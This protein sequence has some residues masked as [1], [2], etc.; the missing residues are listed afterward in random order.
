VF[1]ERQPRQRRISTLPQH[2]GRLQHR[3]S[4]AKTRRG[5]E[6]RQWYIDE[7]AQL[8]KNAPAWNEM[9]AIGG[10]GNPGN[11]Q[12]FAHETP[13]VSIFLVVLYRNSV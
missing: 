12:R 6:K 9:A 11:E 8:C 2:A 13:T 1:V 3:C 5:A 4:F 7:I 10:R